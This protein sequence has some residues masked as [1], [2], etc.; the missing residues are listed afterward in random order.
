MTRVIEPL[1]DRALRQLA[2][3]RDRPD[4]VRRG[5]RALP[6]ER[7]PDGDRQRLAKRAGRDVDP[8][9]HRRRVAFEPA[10]ELP[11]RHELVV[12]DRACRADERIVQRR[13]VVLA[14]DQVVVR[15]VLGARSVVAEMRGQ[16]DGHEVGRGERGRRMARARGRRAADR[17]GAQLARDGLVEVRPYGLLASSSPYDLHLR[18]SWYRPE[19][20]DPSWMR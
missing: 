1:P 5:E 14:E 6:R 10:A 11:E 17:V 9:E 8:R 2:V 19:P 13:R 3:A 16:E 20:P 12:G 18:L 15:G 7:D 4:V